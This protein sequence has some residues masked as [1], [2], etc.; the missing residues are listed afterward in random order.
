MKRL[1]K[2]HN[3]KKKKIDRRTESLWIDIIIGGIS[4][5]VMITYRPPDSNEASVPLI[6]ELARASRY[7]NVCIIIGLEF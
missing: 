6:Q 1:C 5:A 7:N 3:K 2:C 4:F